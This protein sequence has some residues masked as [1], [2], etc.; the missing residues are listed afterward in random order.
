MRE[1]ESPA[2]PHEFSER[3]A[4]LGPTIGAQLPAEMRCRAERPVL[5]IEGFA[6]SYLETGDPDERAKPISDL[7]RRVLEDM[8]VCKFGKKTRHDCGLLT[9]CGR[10]S[11]CS[12]GW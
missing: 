4:A 5:R 8:A 12:I 10:R 7:R 9:S 11:S 3:A 1:T 2:L 6:T